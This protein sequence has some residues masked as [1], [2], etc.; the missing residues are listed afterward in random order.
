MST[1]MKDKLQLG[2]INFI[3]LAISAILLIVGYF[4]MSFNEIVISPIIL[5]IVYVALIPFALLYQPKKK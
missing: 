2:K 1:K 5:S 3:L 4:I